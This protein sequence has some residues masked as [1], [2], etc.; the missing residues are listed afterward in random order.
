MVKSYLPT[1]AASSQ[2][3]RLL[4]Q[5]SQHSQNETKKKQNPQIPS[6]VPRSVYETNCGPRPV[7]E[8]VVEENDLRRCLLYSRA[9]TLNPKPEK[10]A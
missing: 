10:C 1:V 4:K 9:Q 3:P 7:E 6:S 8:E 5:I 2:T